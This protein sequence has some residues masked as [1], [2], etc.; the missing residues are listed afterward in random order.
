MRRLTH[1]PSAD[2]PNK[3]TPNEVSSED[4][5]TNDFVLMLPVEMGLLHYC[6]HFREWECET[7]NNVLKILCE[8]RNRQKWSFLSKFQKL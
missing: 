2:M 8:H 5:T 6:I 3:V 7:Q 1:S 4:F